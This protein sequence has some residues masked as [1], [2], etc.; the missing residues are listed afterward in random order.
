MGKRNKQAVSVLN[1][2]DLQ[3]NTEPIGPDNLPVGMIE[4]QSDYLSASFG[5]PREGETGKCIVGDGNAYVDFTSI[6]NTFTNSNYSFSFW[7]KLYALP[8]SANRI[9]DLSDNIRLVQNTNGSINWSVNGQGGNSS[10]LT[11]GDW[12]H[13]AI[14]W[15]NSSGTGVNI[16][17]NS[18][19]D[20]SLSGNGSVSDSVYLRYLL[21]G[22]FGASTFP[23]T[24]NLFDFKVFASTL[25]VEDIHNLYTFQYKEVSDFFAKL[26]S[27][28]ET[29][30]YDSSGN[31]NHGT[32]INYYS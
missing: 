28:S 19:L 13:I 5:T 6:T 16:Y 27:L 32:I 21:G 29:I 23:S 31:G 7:Y 3:N 15:N 18:E 22:K 1:S 25:S 17:L 24:G 14:V 20:T 26:D 10:I 30:V 12:Y 11:L 2:I 9:F 4:S 8:S